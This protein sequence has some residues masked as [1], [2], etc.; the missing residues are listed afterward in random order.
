MPL[1]AASTPLLENR[2]PPSTAARGGVDDDDGD[3]GLFLWR[4]MDLRESAAVVVVVVGA[5]WRD[6][7][8]GRRTDADRQERA[9][10]RGTGEVVLAVR[11]QNQVVQQ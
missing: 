11:L 7:W 6:I 4:T 8:C 5:V 2:R 1:G 9:N 10:K 3:D